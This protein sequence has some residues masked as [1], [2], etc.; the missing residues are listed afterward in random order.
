[1]NYAIGLDLG[2]TNIKGL[3]VTPGGRVLSE[4]TVPTG[5]DGSVAW[6]EN[7]RSV[8][9]SLQNSSH[10]AADYVGL[11]APG[12]PAPNQ[13]SIAF[14]PGRLRGLEQLVWKEFL[15]VP[16]PV[17][18]LNDAQAALLGEVWRGAATGA[19][20]A[21]LLTLGTGVGG[22]ALVDGRL[23]RGHLGRAGHLGHVSL[24][25]EGALDVTG[26]PGSLENAIGECTVSART[27]GRFATTRELVAAHRRGDPH[28]Q[29]TWLTS[30]RAL[31]AAI[32][33][34]INVLDPEV[35]I[36]GGGITKAGASLFR[37]LNR[38]LDQ[39]EWRPGGARTRVVPARLGDRA[40][41]FGAAWNAI[42]AASKCKPT[43]LFPK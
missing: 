36:L 34:I 7:V 21:V 24:D 29:L 28:A 33:S 40:G 5:D 23:L 31:A 41:A 6:Q 20:N 8:F 4:T 15:A 30:V 2:G 19:S 18:V 38:F 43:T 3:V 10:A 17:P 27:S 22:A 16:V 39:Y 37:P 1:M 9:Q 32:A 42:L 12:L 13:R 25:P 26:T 14:M 35:V 11:A